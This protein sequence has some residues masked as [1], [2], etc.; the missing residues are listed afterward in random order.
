MMPNDPVI[1][2]VILRIPA[3]QSPNFVH[4]V[5]GWAIFQNGSAEFNNITLSGGSLVIGAAGQG[6]FVYSGTPAF[7]NL[8]V[9]MAS[10]SGSDAFGNTYPTGFGVSV[11]AIPG[12][13]INAGTIGTTQIANNAITTALIA[14]AAVATANIANGAVTTTQIAAAAGILGSQLSASANISGSQLAAAAGITAGQVSFSARGIGGITTSVQSTAPAGAVTGDLWFDTSNNNKLNQFAS[15]TWSPYTFGTNA[16]TAGSITAA[17]IAANTITASQIASGTITATQIAAATITG[18]LIAAGTITGTNI[19]AG[20]ITAGL[21]AADAIVAGLIAAGAIDG[22]TI[23]AITINGNTISAADVL[24]SGTNGGVFAYSTGGTVVQTFTTSGTW[25]APA[26]VTSVKVECV[27]GGGGGAGSSATP[28]EGP[29]GG[30]GEYSAEPTNTVVAGD[31]YTI[32]IGAAGSGG[33]FGNG[34]AGGNTSFSGTSAT[35]VTAHGGG[36]GTG[37]GPGVGGTGSTNTTHNDGGTGGNGLTPSGGSGAG[38]GGSASVG[39]SGNP[40]SGGNA[41]APPAVTGGGPGGG[42][43][44]DVGQ[45]PLAGPGGGGGGGIGTT[46]QGGSGFKGQVKLT[47][48]SSTPTLI[49][50]IAGAVGTDPVASDAVGPGVNLIN[51]SAAPAAVTGAALLYGMGGHEKYVST[52]GNV[53]NTGRKTIWFTGTQTISVNGFSTITD[54]TNAFSFPVV[55]AAYRFRARIIYLP[56]ATLGTPAFELTSPAFTNGSCFFTLQ[57]NGNAS[58]F[59]RYSNSSGFGGSFGSVANATPGTTLFVGVDIEGVAQ[60]TASGNLVALAS[61]TGG[62]NF[63]IQKGSFF[64]LLPI[65]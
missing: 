43:I 9:S 36:A 6:V 35:T 8:I 32:T 16:I 1:G 65:S 13:L 25:I 10:A 56:S 37:S 48:T 26:G 47:Y 24:V 55:A 28:D 7:G 59:G 19:A 27:G 33:S 3:I 39:V 31:T 51:A 54:G 52:D 11:G 15:G 41:S 45:I 21:I 12:T 22:M 34:T 20:T 63:V 44:L 58:G 60:F 5:S 62:S 57:Y 30:G 49:A 42:T 50:A 29:G 4:G 2:G 38:S 23:N 46:N 17:L 14:A 61:T 40:I 64:E 18:T 53:Y